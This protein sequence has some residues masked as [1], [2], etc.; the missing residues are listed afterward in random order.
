MDALNDKEF[1]RIRNAC[2][3]RAQ[4]DKQLCSSLQSASNSDTFLTHL[5]H[6][7]IGCVLNILMLLHMLMVETTVL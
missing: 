2:V 7:A 3:N 6:T 4:G 5:L 1:Q